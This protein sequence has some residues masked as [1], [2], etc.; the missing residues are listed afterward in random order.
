MRSQPSL[1]MTL[2]LCYQNKS[3]FKQIIILTEKK[4]TSWVR[5]W[6]YELLPITTQ[7]SQGLNKLYFLPKT[8]RHFFDPE[9]TVLDI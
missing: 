4:L 8:Q 2:T 1:R 5:A 9:S 3:F 7:T 6:G